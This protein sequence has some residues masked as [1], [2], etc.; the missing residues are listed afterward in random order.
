MNP[1]N[2]YCSKQW[3]GQLINFGTKKKEQKQKNREEEG[4]NL[5]ISC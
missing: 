4:W 1:D 2:R 5:E 3:K